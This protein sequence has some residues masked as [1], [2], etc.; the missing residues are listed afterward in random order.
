MIVIDKARVNSFVLPLRRI[1]RYP[2]AFP[3]GTP[4]D[5]HGLVA[6]QPFI[7]RLSDAAEQ[8]RGAY[9]T[10]NNV[11]LSKGPEFTDVTAM[12]N[13]GSRN[14]ISCRQYISGTMCFADSPTRQI[15]ATALAHKRASAANASP[16]LYPYP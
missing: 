4:N 12:P 13:D 16:L 9:C 2:H 6:H 5:S 10:V 3:P 8:L 7:L 14:T 1:L 11:A 15:Q